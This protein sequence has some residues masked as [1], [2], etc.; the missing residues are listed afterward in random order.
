MD[1]GRILGAVLEGQARR[2]ARRTPARTRLPF[3]LTQRDARQISR[4][5]GALAGIAADALERPRGA[6]PASAEPAPPPIRR[7]AEPARRLPET[8]PRPATPAAETREALLLL[9]A[10]IAGAKADGELDREERA[11][12]ARRLDEAGL[13]AE[14]R[15]LV[16]ADFDR[17]AETAALA[18]EARDPM[19]A[20]QIYAAACAG[21]GAISERER[22]W[23]DGLGGALKL[24]AA[25][26]A[27]IET[28]LGG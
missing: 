10:M 6:A 22:A 14:E 21:A 1:L 8:A 26:R 24:S 12:I 15:D 20:A 18:R 13:S 11:A 3:G 9:R 28:R 19:L 25:T 2:P 23:L 27:A 17:P 7:G 5:V 16:L 4:V